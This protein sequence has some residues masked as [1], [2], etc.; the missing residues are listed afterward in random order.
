[1]AAVHATIM[2][3]VKSFNSTITKGPHILKKKK[4][5]KRFCILTHRKPQNIF[6]LNKCHFL[7]GVVVVVRIYNSGDL[8]CVRTHVYRI[9][10][11]D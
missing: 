4:E 9:C 6:L 5:E 2:S 8:E 3:E 1:M 10:C 7:I 11:F